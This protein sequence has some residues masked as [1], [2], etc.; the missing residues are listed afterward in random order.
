MNPDDQD[1]GSMTRRYPRIV[2]GLLPVAVCVGVVLGKISSLSW[3]QLCLVVCLVAGGTMLA[4]GWLLNA[5]SDRK[6]P[7]WSNHQPAIMR[8]HENCGGGVTEARTSDASLVLCRNCGS[9]VGP[10]DIEDWPPAAG[11]RPWRTLC[12]SRPGAD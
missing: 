6:V 3:W 7:Q 1:G 12:A 5:V 2:D 8:V 10:H 4:M 9:I 11:S